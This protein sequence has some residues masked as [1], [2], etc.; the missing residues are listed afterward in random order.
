ML[1]AID[2]GRKDVVEDELDFK[3]SASA[4]TYPVFGHTLD[5]TSTRQRVEASTIDAS[6]PTRRHFDA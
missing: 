4:E 2:A 6:T 5:I 1:T 3:K